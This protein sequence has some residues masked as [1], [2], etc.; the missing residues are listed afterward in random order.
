MAAT[1]SKRLKIA[2]TLGMFFAELGKI[3]DRKEYAR[4]KNRPKFLDAKEVDKIFGTWNRM[5]AFLKKE[6]PD[7]W[8]LMHKAPKEEKEP[9]IES[10]MAQ[11]KTVVKADEE[12]DD[13]KDI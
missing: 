11:A 2:R 10:K 1:H 7:L 13:G 8:D 3:P 4:M 12:G 9:T 6:Y 5:E